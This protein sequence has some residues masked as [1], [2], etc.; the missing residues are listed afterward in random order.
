[1][2]ALISLFLVGALSTGAMFLIY[3]TLGKQASASVGEER[4]I[5]RTEISRFDE[6]I[7]S[8]LAKL[9][10]MVS[11]DEKIKLESEKKTVT[12]AIETENVKVKKLESQL[13]ALQEKM[14]GQEAR[15]SELK[16]GKENSDKFAAELNEAKDSVQSESGTIANSCVTLAETVAK[17]SQN[18]KLSA[19]QT[20]VIKSAQT[21]LT[22]I[23][24]QLKEFTELYSR[25]VGRFVN[26]EKQY[27]ELDKEF[28]RLLDQAISGE[29]EKKENA[30]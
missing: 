18:S 29:E 23:S 27:E 11:L 14:D 9:A 24:N 13:T 28:R 26:L 15:H 1:M 10:D 22:D 2:V 20:V 30:E 6:A 8:A 7:S 16:R 12:S 4:G 21:I 25:A 17:A 19:D 3:R 5:I